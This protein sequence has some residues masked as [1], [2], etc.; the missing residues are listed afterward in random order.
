M[1]DVFDEVT[2]SRMMAG[3]RGK[4][5]RP[6]MIVR[7]ALFRKGFRYKLHDKKLPGRP[8]LVFPKYRAVIFVHGCFWHQHHCHLFKWPATRRDFW[9]AK[10]DANASTD[11]RVVR[12]LMGEGWRIMVIWECALKGRTKLPLEAITQ[13]AATWLTFGTGH[14]E[15]SGNR[16]S[17]F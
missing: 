15:I 14:V 17:P 13:R 7:K 11:L 4:D 5:T 6:E 1:A 3:I 16:E 9:K 10:L 8:D 12:R 2:R